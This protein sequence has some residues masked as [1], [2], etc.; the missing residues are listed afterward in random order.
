MTAN[1]THTISYSI[2][3]TRMHIDP[4]IKV[5]VQASETEVKHLVEEGYFVRER[6]V[7]G[8]LL[9]SLR[10]AAD[11]LEAEAAKTQGQGSTG[12][13]SGLFIRG[14]IDKHPVF[15][16]ALLR[17]QPTLSVARAVLGPQVQIHASVLRIAYP[18][19]GDQRVEWHFHQRV[20][21]SPYPPFFLR[22]VVL[23]NLIYLDDIT[24]DS[25][26]LV[27]LPRTHL[28]DED[29][30]KEDHSDKPGQVVITCPAGTCVTSHS[31]LW[32]KAM[33]TLATG[34]KRRLLILGY[35]PVWLKPI[36]PTAAMANREGLTRTLG[37]SKDEEIRELLGLSGYY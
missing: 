18:E 14:L 8:D 4:P 28:I 33:P 27:V 7:S 30:P 5:N 1:T 6:L 16:E 23:D 12:S 13:F 37:N 31:S 25:G 34:N 3:N 22:P 21:P 26:P 36:D 24:M 2:R 17:F 10:N 29:L 9:E 19:V 11:E 15:L 20:V 32:H 35:S